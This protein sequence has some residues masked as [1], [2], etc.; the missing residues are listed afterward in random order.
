MRVKLNIQKKLLIVCLALALLPMAVLSFV[1]WRVQSSISISYA[2]QC[3]AAASRLADTID[4]NLFERYGDVQAFGVNETAHNKELWYQT[5]EETPLIRAM[6]SYVDLYDIYYLT[7]MVDLDG[8][9]IAVNTKDHEGKPI[10]TQALYAKNFAN[11]P[12][13]QNTKAERFSQAP[14]STLTGTVLEDIYIDEDVKGIYGDEGLTIG[15]C[16]PVKD[17]SG[18]IIAYW[19]NFA[20]FSLV[21]EIA[22]SAYARMN[23]MGLPKTEITLLDSQ[24]RLLLELAPSRTGSEKVQRDMKLVLQYSEKEKGDAAVKELLSDKSGS[25]VHSS[26]SRHPELKQVAGYAPFQGALGFAGM[27][28]F[29]MV[30]VE[31]ADIF[32]ALHEAQRSIYISVGVIAMIAVATSFLVAR[33]I[34]KPINVTTAML[35]DIAQGEGDLTRRL[36]DQRHDELGELAKWFNVFVAR[37]QSIVRQ[38]TGNA[39]VLN[40]TSANLTSA[41]QELNEGASQ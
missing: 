1:I 3:E 14:G 12:W 41:A 40:S 4:R 24:G 32:A 21:E 13:F 31:H 39:T 16:A 19:K 15:F 33:M 26:N 2:N 29:S 5:T 10:Q 20:K 11:K 7:L 17:T 37:I 35:R 28:W 25:A 6:N 8:K 27:P 34:V 30:R 36:D 9:V 18:K 22:E 38:L 23:K